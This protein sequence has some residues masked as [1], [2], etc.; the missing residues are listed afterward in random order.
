LGYKAW[1][2]LKLKMEADEN[3]ARYYAGKREEERRAK[4]RK[5]A[6]I[7][8]LLFME[9]ERKERDANFFKSKLEPASAPAASSSFCNLDSVSYRTPF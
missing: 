6:A 3:V 5:L 9:P 8:A 1:K 7:T 4:K 2:A